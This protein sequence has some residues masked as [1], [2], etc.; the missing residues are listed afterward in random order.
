[1]CAFFVVPSFSENSYRTDKT[2]AEQ[3]KTVR[4]FLKRLYF[5][6]FKNSISALISPARSLEGAAFKAR[7]K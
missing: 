3:L 6:F 1:M 5:C 4:H 7:S 2:A